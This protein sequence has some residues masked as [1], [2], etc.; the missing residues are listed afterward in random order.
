MPLDL[1]QGKLALQDDE[2]LDRSGLMTTMDGLKVEHQTRTARY[3]ASSS[4][5]PASRPWP[6]RSPLSMGSYRARCVTFAPPQEC[7]TRRAGPWM[8]SH[9]ARATEAVSDS[10]CLR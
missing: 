4:C 5:R 8:H 7:P 3:M 10:A 1:Q 6:R 2:A 9:M